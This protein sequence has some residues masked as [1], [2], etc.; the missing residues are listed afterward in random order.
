MQ[1]YHKDGNEAG[2]SRR[3]VVENGSL[4]NQHAV[5]D[6]VAEAHL[7]ALCTHATRADASAM[8]ARSVPELLAILRAELPK[9]GQLR[10]SK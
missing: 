2:E 6:E 9:S 4:S 3:P 8:K 1:A 7:H 5:E 10:A